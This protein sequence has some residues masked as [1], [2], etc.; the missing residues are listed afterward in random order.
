M[1][2]PLTIARALYA[3]A[4]LAYDPGTG[5]DRVLGLIADIDDSGGKQHLLESLGND[6]RVLEA[7]REKPELGVIDLDALETLPSDSLGAAHAA[8][9]RGHGFDP[10]DITPDPNVTDE[11]ADYAVNHL[12]ETHDLWHVLTGFGTDVA[13]ELGL[14]A[15]YLAQIRGPV[16][17][18]LLAG[19]LL[20][21]LRHGSDE[22]G[23]RMDNIA[24]GWRLGTQARPLFG[25]RW[26]ERWGE[27]IEDIRG[28]LALAA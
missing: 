28:E 11:D 4:H 25:I 17:L 22:V 13:G 1:Q 20:N 12:R 2:N 7:L 8:F 26:A 15:F 5:T 6:E 23:R 16:P 10:G 3:F 14:Q 19:G 21:G 9:L 24:R 27:P 18:I